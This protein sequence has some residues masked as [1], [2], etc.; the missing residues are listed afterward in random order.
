MSS[1]IGDREHERRVALLTEARGSEILETVCRPIAWI[2]A[3]MGQDGVLQDQ[4]AHVGCVRGPKS[5][6]QGL[7]TLEEV[8]ESLLGDLREARSPRTVG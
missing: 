8:L 3:S 2:D 7:I 6:V 5:D 4:K 1:V